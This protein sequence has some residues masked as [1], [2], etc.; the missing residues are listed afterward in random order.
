METQ[1]KGAERKSAVSIT[2]SYMLCTKT[3]RAAFPLY[4]SGCPFKN[5]L[6]F[7]YTSVTSAYSVDNI[8]ACF[9]LVSLYYLM[10]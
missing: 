3:L 9:M 8:S 2:M 5:V 4:V 10:Q 1:G 6:Q 7:F